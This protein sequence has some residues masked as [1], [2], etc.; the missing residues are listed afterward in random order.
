M[1]T[2]AQ[3]YNSCSLS[4]LPHFMGK[5]QRELRE[6]IWFDAGPLLLIL[7]NFGVLQV[8]GVKTI[9]STRNPE[10]RNWVA[11]VSVCDSS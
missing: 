10:G 4:S 9:A 11:S 1:G 3:N 8:L 5:V 6:K 2:K 7:E